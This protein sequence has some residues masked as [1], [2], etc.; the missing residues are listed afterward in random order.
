MIG[1]CNTSGLALLDLLYIFVEKFIY[2]KRK[3]IDITDST[4]ETLNA[5]AARTGTNL[6]NY[7]ENMLDHKARYLEESETCNYRL[8]CSEEPSDKELS[9]IMAKAAETAANRKAEA[10]SAF[11]SKL[12]EAV[13]SVN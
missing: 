3:L 13:K 10:M 2:M 8:S 6:K 11:Y 12:E 7:I 9:I 5:E 1:F 4:F